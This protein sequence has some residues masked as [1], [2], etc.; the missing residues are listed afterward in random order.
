MRIELEIPKAFEEH[1][2]QDK[3]KNS[4]ERIMV[5]IFHS[6][7][8]GD[9]LCAGRYEYETIKMLAEAF[10]DSKSAYDVDKVVEELEKHKDTTD[11]TTV[12]EEMVV[13]FTIYQGA[14]ND[15]ID[16]AIEIVKQGG[17]SDDTDNMCEWIKY[18][19]K[20]ICPK[21]H[22]VNNPYWRIPDN[23]DKLKYC[24]YCGKKILCYDE[25]AE[26]LKERK[27]K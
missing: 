24:P 6:L 16:K 25:I 3:F 7:E 11:L 2:K 9:C 4:L 21:N 17:V 18:D 23:M 26:Q 14:F 12:D 20:T 22:D 19:Y 27:E 1:F 8:N 13:G 10:E 5:D 15:A